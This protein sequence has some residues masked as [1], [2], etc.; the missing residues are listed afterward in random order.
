MTHF[1]CCNQ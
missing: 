1:Y